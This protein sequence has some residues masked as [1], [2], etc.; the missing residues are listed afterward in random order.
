MKF[1]H[2]WIDK[3]IKGLDVDL[4]NK[5]KRARELTPLARFLHKPHVFFLYTIRNN[6]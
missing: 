2:E 5:K 6:P 3:T 4:I 1:L